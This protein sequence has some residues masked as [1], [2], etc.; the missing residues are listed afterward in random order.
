MISK[1]ASLFRTLFSVVLVLGGCTAVSAK[2]PERPVIFVHGIIG[3][4]LKDADDKIIWGDLSSLRR[5]NFHSMNLL[6]NTGLP[7]ELQ[8]TDALRDLPLAFGTIEVGLYS[9]I[10]DFLD[11]TVSMGDSLRGDIYRGEYTEGENLFVF[12]YD[13]RR[14]NFLNALQLNEFIEENIPSGEYD[15]IAHSMGGIVARIMLS[16]RGPHWL[17]TRGSAADAKLS[18]SDYQDLCSA[19][20]G[21]SPHGSYPS[22]FLDAPRTAADRL[23][24][25]VELAVPHY[26]SV[27]LAA[28]LLEGW[29]RVSEILL[30]GKRAIQ[31]T[32]L[33]FSAPVELLPTYD[34]CC[35]R[36]A[37][38]SDP[39]RFAIATPYNE[40][41]WLELMLAFGEE[42]CPYSRCDVRRALFRNGIENRKIIDEIMDAGLP[43][44][45]KSNH[46][47]I[48]RFVKNTRQTVYVDF[49]AN[50]D[51]D[52]VSFRVNAQGDGTVHKDSALL[53]ANQHNETWQ[54]EY[55]V[56]HAKHP[57]IVGDR[58]TTEYIY[59]MLV[60]PVRDGIQG[61]SGSPVVFA[62]S[63]I[64]EIGLVVEDSVLFEEDLFG[65][66]LSIDFAAVTGFDAEEARAAEIKVMLQP[67]YQPNAAQSVIGT[68]HFDQG[69]SL[70]LSGSLV[71]TASDLSVTES[72]IYTINLEY[73]LEGQNRTLA[74]SYLYV[75]APE[76]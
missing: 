58:N 37:G 3:S 43:K 54:N 28:T 16:Q 71:Y 75:L 69:A 12:A 24:T 34:F 47:I 52:G 48:G 5:R 10:I 70:L 45:V 72:G 33:S 25:F 35:A 1:I 60:D 53:P 68:M 36:G 59:N 2:P 17:C 14:S 29:G 23:H 64:G 7:A 19:A 44:T 20:Y 31:D 66:T 21:P 55:V 61:V 46:G 50:G 30:G 13:W 27:N 74:K 8:A 57:F 26:G 63:P 32:I 67:V 76:E 42:H 56:M 73:K 4:T 15:I 41:Y 51:G 38:P 62:G 40:E 11:G 65:A 22:T 6:P 49:G 39:D 18:D 9:S